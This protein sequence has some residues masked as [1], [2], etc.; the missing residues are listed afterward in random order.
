MKL[1]HLIALFI[2]I[3]IIA[4]PYILQ[5]EELKTRE[6]DGIARAGITFEEDNT[7]LFASVEFIRGEVS[8]SYETNFYLSIV[9]DGY[10]IVDHTFSCSSFYNQ[11]LEFYAEVGISPADNNFLGMGF[12]QYQAK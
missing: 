2:G 4:L 6:N 10:G 5:A 11:D 8:L 7:L 12:R 1:K 9:T 3:I